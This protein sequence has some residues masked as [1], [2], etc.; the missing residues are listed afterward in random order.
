MGLPFFISLV[1]REAIRS[2]LVLV[3]NL[4]EEVLVSREL[5]VVIREV[6]QSSF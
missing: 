3:E 5:A 2:A 1:L 6:S 4:W